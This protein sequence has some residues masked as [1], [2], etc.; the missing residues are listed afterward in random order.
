M[1]IRRNPD[2]KRLTLNLARMCW[3]ITVVSFVNWKTNV[4][5]EGKKGTPLTKGTRASS[6]K[7]KLQ[8]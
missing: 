6:V 5:I 4:S 7:H 1:E 8:G 2:L 3:V